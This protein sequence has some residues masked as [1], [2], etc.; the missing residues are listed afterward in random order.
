M[1]SIYAQIAA[2]L[3]AAWVAGCVIGFERSFHGRAAGIRTH[4]VVAIAAAAT[5]MVSLAPAFAPGGSFPGGTPMLDPTRLAQGVMT[6]VGFLGAGVIFKEG[7]NVQGLTTAASIWATAAIGLLLGL[8][9][10]WPGA[11]ATV[12]VL[13]T[14]MM[15]RWLEEILPMQVYAWCVFRFRVAEAPD[16]AGLAS[17]VAGH[18]VTLRELSYARSQDGAILEFSGNVMARRGQA[19]EEL[20]STLRTLDGLVEFELSRI[21]K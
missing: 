18:G 11:I 10:Y 5:V 9:E 20:A 3:T 6:G 8:G 12:A 2:E 16:N 17:L 14:L 13:A 7:V 19:F 4:A 21:G 15:L 1:T